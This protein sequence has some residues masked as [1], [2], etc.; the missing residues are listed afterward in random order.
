MTRRAW[1]QLLALAALWGA[2]YPL[3]EIILRELSPVLVVLGRVFLAAGMLVPVAVRGGSL[4]NLWKHPRAIVET[5]LVQSTVPL[6]LLTLGQQYVP[7]GI[8]G[9]LIG[10]QPLFVA[11]LAMRFDPAERPA[12]WAGGIGIMLGLMGLVLLFGIELR[13]GWHAFVGGAL[14]LAAALSY[15]AGSIMIHK[16]HVDAPPVGVA[17][18]AMLVT[19]VAMAIPAVASLPNRMPGAEVVGALAILGVFCTGLPLVVFY[20]LISDTGPARAALAFFLSPAFAV[21]FGAILLDETLT[22]SVVAGLIA[23]VAGSALASRRA[24][25]LST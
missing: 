4:R 10:A 12:G 19:A 14:V 13:G 17:T 8:A 21:A 24:E 2:V 7:S 23:I 20:S 18:S 16:R 22:T 1:A 3:N 6:L 5:A 11:L 15:A 25:T 9:I